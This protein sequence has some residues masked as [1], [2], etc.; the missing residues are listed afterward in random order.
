MRVAI[1][2]VASESE[3][4]SSGLEGEL[5]VEREWR[6]NLQSTLVSDKEKIAKLQEEITQLQALSSVSVITEKSVPYSSKL[7]IFFSNIMY[8]SCLLYYYANSFNKLI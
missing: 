4:R 8:L 5:R 7:I 3:E 6:Q 2:Q 1:Q